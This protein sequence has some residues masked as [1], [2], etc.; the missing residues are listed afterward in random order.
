MTILYENVF[1]FKDSFWKKMKQTL[2]KLGG[3]LIGQ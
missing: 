1:D 2:K 3:L